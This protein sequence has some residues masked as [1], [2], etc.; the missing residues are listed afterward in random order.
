M[1]SSMASFHDL[2]SK[3]DIPLDKA[4]DVNINEYAVYGEQVPSAG[5]WWIAGLERENAHGLRGNWAIAGALHD[6]MAGLLSKPNGSGGSYAIEGEGY[7]PTAEFQ[8]YRYYASSMKGQRLRTTASSDG[9]F[10]AYATVEGDVVRILAGTRSRPGNWTIDVVGLT[11]DTRVKVKTLA[12]RVVDGDR[13]KR[14]DRPHDLEEREEVVKEGK[15][16]LRMKHQDPTTA[17]A[18]ELSV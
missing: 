15:L 12:F 1:A 13:F 16:K 11:D 7:W 2:L 5:A 17:F 4:Q 14:V 3:H 9:L 6:F 8:V 10:D 18:F